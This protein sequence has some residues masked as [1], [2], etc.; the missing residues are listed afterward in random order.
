MLSRGLRHIGLTRPAARVRP[1]RDYKCDLRVSPLGHA[2]VPTRQ[3]SIDRAHEVEVGRHDYGSRP[4]TLR[5]FEK[6]PCTSTRLILPSR[7]RTAAAHSTSKGIP[8]CGH[9]PAECT[10]R[11]TVLCSS[12]RSIFTNEQPLPP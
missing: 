6:S 4:T 10:A 3:R 11:T 5:A 1:V 12:S 2:E 9:R 7:G 8:H